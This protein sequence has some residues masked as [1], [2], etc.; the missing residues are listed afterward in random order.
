M[1][2]RSRD[3]EIQCHSQSS[4]RLL[5]PLR[6]A[7]RW[8]QPSK[9]GL[10]RFG[11]R[12]ISTLVRS[13]SCEPTVVRLG[14]EMSQDRHSTL[15]GPVAHDHHAQAGQ[16]GHEN[17]DSTIQPHAYPEP[18]SPSLPVMARPGPATRTRTSERLAREREQRSAHLPRP[19]TLA[20]NHSAAN[21]LSDIN[22]SSDGAEDMLDGPNTI[23]INVLAPYIE[24]GP[25]RPRGYPVDKGMTVAHL[26]DALCAGKYGGMPCRRDKMKIICKGRLLEEEEK[27]GDVV[28]PV[29]IIPI[30][31]CSRFL[32]GHQS[33][34]P[35]IPTGSLAGVDSY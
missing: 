16:A 12:C 4:A 15:R 30:R 13:E 14:L 20:P 2:G 28:G 27:L 24:Q 10:K 33:K 11:T 21:R 23:R 17:I 9:N 32:S 5:Y 35:C 25:S 7:P 26:K 22:G 31:A 3:V 18:S 19:L 6:Q 29:C 34:R 8:S 1:R